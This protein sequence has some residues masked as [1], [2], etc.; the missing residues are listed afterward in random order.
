MVRC[1]SRARGPAIAHSESASLI[2]AA[3]YV[4][5]AAL[6]LSTL[7][8]PS[9]ALAQDSD[10]C[11]DVSAQLESA[12]ADLDQLRLDATPWLVDAS[13]LSALVTSDLLV[14]AQHGAGGLS[15]DTAA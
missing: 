15:P 12:N 10:D 8:G 7:V 14:A 4:L 2:G 11:D 9:V 13:Q 6:V 3:P 5:A 1:T